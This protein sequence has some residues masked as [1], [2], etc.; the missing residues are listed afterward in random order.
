MIVSDRGVFFKGFVDFLRNLQKGLE[1]FS[2]IET[3]FKFRTMYETIFK[4][5]F[6]YETLFGSVW[7]FFFSVFIVIVNIL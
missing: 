2:K 3:F 6:M 4:F 1:F 5:C 7:H